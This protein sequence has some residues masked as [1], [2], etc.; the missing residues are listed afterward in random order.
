MV[1]DQSDTDTPNSVSSD[2]FMYK[3]ADMFQV[4]KAMKA[5]KPNPKDYSV[6]QS[7]HNQINEILDSVP[8]TIRHENPDTS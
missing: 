6:A 5:D 4:P 1:Q 3:L 7:V 8:P 2:L